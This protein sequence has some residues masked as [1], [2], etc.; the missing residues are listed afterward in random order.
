MAS[1]DVVVELAA[2]SF[3]RQNFR[4]ISSSV[5][6]G[7]IAEAYTQGAVVNGANFWVADVLLNLSNSNIVG[8]PPILFDSTKSYDIIVRE[9]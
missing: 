6:P 7:Y 1:G 5:G 8:D 4:G 3:N 9:H 2:I